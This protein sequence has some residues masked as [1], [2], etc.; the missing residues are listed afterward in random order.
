MLNKKGDGNSVSR[1][2]VTQTC[3]EYS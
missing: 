1:A 2:P 3:K